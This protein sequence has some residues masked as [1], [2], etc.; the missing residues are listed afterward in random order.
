M[1][2]YTMA[3]GELQ[4]N[5]YIIVN[6][7]TKQ[8]V[9]VDPGAEAKRI[10]DFLNSN[11]LKLEAILLTHGHADHIGALDKVRA[12]TG[13][14]VYIHEAD[15][16]MLSN[17]AANL[18]SFIGADRTYK[19]AEHFVQDG[20]FLNLAGMQIYVMHTP[21]HT[22]GGCCYALDKDVIVG[23]TIFCESIGRTDLPGGSYKQLLTGIKEKILTLPD[24][25]KLYPGHGP[26]T[27]VA[28]ERK[29]NP[30]LQ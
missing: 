18:S 3:L 2:I 26:A 21:G 6:E 12:Q 23:D 19:P 27:D 13:A 14:P 17:A 28:W 29:M 25:T 10:T 5:C 8:A 20:D 24:D 15:A 16:P 9:L 4:T 22:K 30:F 11:E 1:K 7:Q